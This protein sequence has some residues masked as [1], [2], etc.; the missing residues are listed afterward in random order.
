MTGVGEGGEG[1][2]SRPREFKHVMLCLC[3]K[4]ELGIRAVSTCEI[5][6][7]N[8]LALGSITWAGSVIPDVSE[9]E[10]GFCGLTLTVVALLAKK[11][12]KRGTR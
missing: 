10:R 1:E 3:K 9:N 7:F 2:G 8:Y 5:I 4:S 12:F 6:K 11:T